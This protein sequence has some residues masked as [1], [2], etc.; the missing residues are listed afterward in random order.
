M[1][2]EVA[3]VVADD[4]LADMLA[5]AQSPEPA[6]GYSVPA[7]DFPVRTSPPDDRFAAAQPTGLP[8]NERPWQDGL[9]NSFSSL[10]SST[11]KVPSVHYEMSR[12]PPS[13]AASMTPP[14]SNLSA[15]TS[16]SA[17][18]P[19]PYPMNMGYYPQQPW[20]QPYPAAYPYPVP[21]MPGYGYPAYPYAPVHPMAP[22]Y[23]PGDSNSNG[24]STSTQWNGAG[25]SD[26][27]SK[28]RSGCPLNTRES[29]PIRLEQNMAGSTNAPSAPAGHLAQPPL[30]ATSFIQNEHG[31][32]IP[33]YQREAL[34]EYMA[35]AHH[36]RQ[37][38]H[39]P[40]AG[41]QSQGPPQPASASTPPEGVAWQP[42]LPMYPGP[43]PMHM[44][45]V[46]SMPV[47]PAHQ[48]QQPR[49]WM[50]GPMPYGVPAFHPQNPHATHGMPGPVAPVSAA[51]VNHQHARPV[52]PAQ[53]QA[54][55][56]QRSRQPP[57][58]AGNRAYMPV[59]M[60]PVV[61]RPPSAAAGDRSSV[62]MRDVRGN[63]RSR[64]HSLDPM[65]RVRC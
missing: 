48:P 37:L 1:S 44:Q 65:E 19:A 47:P 17:S 15:S 27:A 23:V 62:A 26:G 49:F 25:G 34:D 57:A 32:L 28:V 7:Q 12:G 45:P 31:A 35:H 56:A 41:A 58:Q 63:G 4:A 36:G 46:P 11:T 39:P 43:Y 21:V 13:T 5:D 29:S 42:S 30:R 40:P 53:G 61:T 33:V 50:S 64:G 54:H 20:V 52:P 14:P 22:A 2:N 24:N 9:N 60:G 3:G 51:S 6:V 55:V 8:A 10:S 16:A 38:P 18:M 59:Q